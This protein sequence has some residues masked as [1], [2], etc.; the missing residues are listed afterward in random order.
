MAPLFARGPERHLFHDADG[1]F[2]ATE[3][4]SLNDLQV[5]DFIAIRVFFGTGKG[6]NMQ[7]DGGYLDLKIEHI[8]GDTVLAVILTELSEEYPL[9]AGGSLEI[10]EDEILY[11]AVV[12]VH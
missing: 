5:D 11:K 9:K 4:D 2:V 1:F 8:D 7:I 10:F 12:T 6:K 3:A